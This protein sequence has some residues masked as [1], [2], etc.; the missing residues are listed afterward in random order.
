M[1]FGLLLGLLVMGGCGLSPD[2]MKQPVTPV[3]DVAVD[4]QPAT[5]TPP[6]ENEIYYPPPFETL[7][8]STPAISF[9]VTWQKPQ[10]VSATVLGLKE[11]TYSVSEDEA[12]HNRY[13]KVGTTNYRNQPAEVYM[14]A[15]WAGEMPG[16]APDYYFLVKQGKKV[17]LI[18][19]VTYYISANQQKTGSITSLHRRVFIGANSRQVFELQGYKD[20]AMVPPLV[21]AFTA[22]SVGQVYVAT[23]TGAY[24]VAMGPLYGIYALKID[25][26]DKDSLVPKITW[27]DGVKNTTEYQYTTRGGCGTT[28][29]LAIVDVPKSELVTVGKNN[30]GDTI[31]GLKNSN[32]Q[33]LKDLYD[34]T[35][36]PEEKLSYEEFLAKRP[37]VY[38]ISPLGDTVALQNNK[39]GIQAECGKPVIYLYPPK[40]TDVRV[41]LQPQGGFT[42]SE[43]EYIVD[44]RVKAEPNG[45]LTDL[46]TNKEYPYLFWEGRG[47]LYEQPKQG[48]VVKKANVKSFLQEKLR[49]LGLNKNE[50]NDFMEFWLPRMEAKPYYFI[51]FMGNS[52]MDR[53]AALTVE[54]KPDTVIRVLMDFTPLDKPISVKG[55][56]IKTPK[57]TGFTVIEWGGVLR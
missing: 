16:F 43:P 12:Y 48:W 56:T 10:K 17:E 45:H 24:Y 28:N 11:D 54:P 57:R 44:W 3:L 40:T 50:T 22:P 42:Y 18:E 19:G 33:R 31:Y 29:Y 7:V 41:V 27:N 35:Y 34:S 55:F 1:A 21:P 13:Y 37:L 47:G 38:W 26:F 32:D 8:S 9:T 53:L 23:T 51:T 36:F 25:F 20:F 4:V 6:V 14:A 49:Q 2:I 5:E 46:R 52:T 15:V 30:L 39:F